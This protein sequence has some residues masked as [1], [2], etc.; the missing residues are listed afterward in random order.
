M[1]S[2]GWERAMIICAA[3][4]KTDFAIYRP[5]TGTWYII[6]SRNDSLT[7]A[8]FGVAGHSP[9]PADYNG[10]GKADIAVFISSSAT[11]YLMRSRAV[12]AAVQLGVSGD[13][14]TPNAFVP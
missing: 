2:G 3:I 12:F 13:T 6:N 10:D 9:V 7:I 4:A 1:V 11:W 14:P 8:H 5:T